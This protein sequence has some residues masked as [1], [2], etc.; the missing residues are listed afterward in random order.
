MKTIVLFIL[1]LSFVA[2]GNSGDS[3]N[4]KST[5]KKANTTNP[6]NLSEFELVNGIG[7]VKEEIVLGDL[8]QKM[9]TEGKAIFEQNCSACHKIAER[10]VGPEVDLILS[11][12]T[13]AYVMNMIMNP[14]EMIKKHP[15]AKKKFA[16]FLTPMPYQN[17]TLE[18]ARSIVEYIRTVQK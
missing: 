15:E 3:P 7:P 5:P 14:A 2:C 12:R 6:F 4:Q 16:E 9:A 11:Y 13:A 17:V 8:N 10:Y 1:A 18:Q